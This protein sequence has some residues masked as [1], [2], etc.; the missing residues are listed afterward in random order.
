MN[1]KYIIN[2]FLSTFSK[3]YDFS[4]IIS[5]SSFTLRRSQKYSIT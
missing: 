1:T 3:P 5:H 2:T 4:F